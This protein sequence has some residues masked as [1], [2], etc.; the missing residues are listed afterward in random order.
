MKLDG[1]YL[2]MRN[3]N[4]C[5]QFESESELGNAKFVEFI[6]LQNY[7]IGYSDVIIDSVFTCGLEVN[8]NLNL[9]DQEQL[10]TSSAALRYIDDI[11]STI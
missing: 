6:I 7:E 10:G 3:K 8:R 2:K 4:S 5:I 1:S 9:N 11:L